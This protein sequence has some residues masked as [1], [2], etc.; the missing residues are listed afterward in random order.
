MSCIVTRAV[1]PD[2][3]PL[4]PQ[5][6]GAIIGFPTPHQRMRPGFSWS[7]SGAASI[8]AS[9]TF[10]DHERIMS[11]I[12]GSSDGVALDLCENGDGS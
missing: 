10:M 5:P 8:P 7:R 2:D 11:R 4:V 6:S 1:R 9:K 12:I 3:D